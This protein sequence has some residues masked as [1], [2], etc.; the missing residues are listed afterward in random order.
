MDEQH[1]EL[2][3][4]I[5]GYYYEHNLKQKEIAERTGYSRSMVSRLLAE[6]REKGVVEVSINY[7][8]KRC[9][10]IE[11]ALQQALNLRIVRVL[12]RGALGYDQMLRKLGS[13]A[14]RL[15]E[16]LVGAG[17]RKIG[18]AWG[19]ALWETTSAL[20]KSNY[21]DSRIYQIIGASGSLDPEI[22]GPNLARALAEALGGQYFTI[23]APLIVESQVTRD[24]LLHDPIV[25]RV[26]QESISLDLALVG[27][28]SMAPDSSTWVRSGYLNSEQLV[29]L[30]N[31][32]AVGD[33]CGNIFD[34]TGIILNDIPIRNRIVGISA[35][36]L[37]KIPLKLGISA[38]EMKI[39]P[40]LGACRANLVNC[41]V[42]DEVAGLSVLEAFRE[43]LKN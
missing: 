3:A 40:I 42:T 11:E 31:Q 43:D 4:Q 39:Q 25:A 24:A 15:I 19:T 33:V 38:G 18:I 5:A 13:M 6:A 12:S 7:P 23:P 1:F 21:A 26:M 8:L 16:E 30:A 32:G 28:G 36:D 37:T 9:L 10:D 17:A 41:L 34:R 14:A 20:R 22:D 2:L 35:D 29:S 27:I